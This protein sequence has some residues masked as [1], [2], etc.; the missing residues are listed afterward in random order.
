M[1]YNAK[2]GNVLIK[3][4]NNI[5]LWKKFKKGFTGYLLIDAG[6]RQLYQEGY[7][8]NRIRLLHSSFLIHILMINWKKGEKLYS[9]YLTDINY[10]NNTFNW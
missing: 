4:D 6:I 5:S 9:N 7:V 10:S 1:F 2:W 8:H 3:W